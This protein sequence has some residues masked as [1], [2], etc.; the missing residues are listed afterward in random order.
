LIEIF[1]KSEIYSFFI[2][3]AKDIQKGEAEF[4][5]S[6]EWL[7][8]WW[9]ADELILIKL[10]TENK[11]NNFYQEAK[12]EIRGFLEQRNLAFPSDLLDESI[13]LNQKLIKLPF[14]YSDLDIQLSYNI[15]EIYENALKG[16]VIPIKKGIHNYHIDRSGKTWSSWQ[17]WCREVI[18]YENKKGAYL[19]PLYSEET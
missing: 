18:W 4:C 10:C 17:D 1:T 12:Q 2:N 7:N 5:Q 19:Y 16:K 13:Y 11:L 9:P 8:I 14:Q 6:K 3:K 15:F